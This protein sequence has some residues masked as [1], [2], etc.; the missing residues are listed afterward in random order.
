[1]PEEAKKSLLINSVA[2]IK[3]Y[4]TLKEKELNTFCF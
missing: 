2:K 3:R 4:K 1:M